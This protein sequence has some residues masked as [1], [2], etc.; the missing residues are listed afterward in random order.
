M[1][2]VLFAL[3]AAVVF[4]LTLVFTKFNF[5][6]AFLNAIITVGLGLL[7]DLIIGTYFVSLATLVQL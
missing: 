6:K 7:I 2:T 5:K 1:F 3:V 4:A